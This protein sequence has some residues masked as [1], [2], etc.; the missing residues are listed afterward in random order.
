MTK[1]KDISLET[2]LRIVEQLQQQELKYRAAIAEQKDRVVVKVAEQVHC[3][4]KKEKRIEFI[5]EQEH[6]Y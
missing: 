2:V 1:I 6:L 3:Q 4:H 5:A